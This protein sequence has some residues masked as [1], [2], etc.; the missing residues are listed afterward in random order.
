MVGDIREFL[1]YGAVE[2]IRRSLPSLILAV[3]HLSFILF[4]TLPNSTVQ[5]RAVSSDSRTSCLKI[6]HA[7]KSDRIMSGLC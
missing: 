2:A 7:E 5:I 6:L 4:M 3:S 1:M